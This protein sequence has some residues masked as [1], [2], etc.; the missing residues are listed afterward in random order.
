MCVCHTR[1]FKGVSMSIV[2]RS[3]GISEANNNI[4]YIEHAVMAASAC[5]NNSTTGLD[6]IDLLVNV[7]NY[8]DNNLCEPSVAALIQHELGINLNP[9]KYPVQSHTFSFD[10]MNGA[11]GMLSALQVVH[12]ILTAK[13]LTRA[14]I[15]S[16]DCHPSTKSSADFPIHHAGAALLLE[17]S[18][19]EGFSQFSFQTTPSFEGQSGYLDLETHKLQSRYS[20][21]LEDSTDIEHQFSFAQ[22]VIQSHIEQH[23]I[24]PSSTKLLVSH[25][26]ASLVNRLGSTLGMTL[27]SGTTSLV[28]IGNIHTASLG[29]ALHKSLQDLEESNVLCVSIGSGITVG[30]GLYRQ[31][32]H[33]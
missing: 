2:I 18:N 26:D 22:K 13:G 29:F 21:S 20:V 9:L 6:E 25:H 24:E 30:C 23:N 7:G 32:V 19:R 31:M 16:G 27:A 12:A 17:R 33:S 4:G 14:V 8:R 15:V 1:G 10:L 3:S 5:L 11:C 28:D